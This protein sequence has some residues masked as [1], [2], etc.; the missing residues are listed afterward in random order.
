MWDTS[1][2]CFATLNITLPLCQV[3]LTQH[4][5]GELFKEK[6]KMEYLSINAGGEQ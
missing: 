6:C 4:T 1:L 3:V 2:G 5:I